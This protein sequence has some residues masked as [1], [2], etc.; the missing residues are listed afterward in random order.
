MTD[1]TPEHRALFEPHL[2][3]GETLHWTGVPSPGSVDYS[4]MVTLIFG[5]L[6]LV[7]WCALVWVTGVGE[8]GGDLP[9]LALF[10]LTLLLIAPI[11]MIVFAI[12]GLGRAKH[13]VYAISSQHLFKFDPRWWGSM[14][15][16]AL[17]QV[18]GVRKRSAT[19][20]TLRFKG[21]SLHEEHGPP[22]DRFVGLADP[23]HVE[24]LI[25]RLISQKDTP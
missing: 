6:C 18:K 22:F 11:V 17:S 9:P 21:L 12:R 16:V 15:R 4:H 13:Y 25:L 2:A 8:L 3:A 20:H 10:V 14:R 23:D 24:A 1:I 19:S 7:F 5:V